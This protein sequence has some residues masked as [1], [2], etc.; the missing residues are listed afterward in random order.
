VRLVEV[1]DGDA[2][3]SCIG[4]RRPCDSC[5]RWTLS[6]PVVRVRASKASYVGRS[7]ASGFFRTSS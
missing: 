2:D 3:V 4:V 7:R 5:C 6:L 1:R